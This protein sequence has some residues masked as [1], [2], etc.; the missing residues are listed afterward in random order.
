MPVFVC[1]FAR[2][3]L[4]EAFGI[5][6]VISLA[7]T[8]V[9]IGF[10]AELGVIL[11]MTDP[12][13][14]GLDR[15]TQLYGLAC[16]MAT[17]IIGSLSYIIV[18]KV[19]HLHH[20]VILF[21]F[22]WVAAIETSVITYFMDGFRL[23]ACGI[24][25]WLLTVLSVLSFYA[26]MLLTRALQIEEAGIVSVSRSSAELVLA[27]IFQITLFRQIPDGCT[28]IGSLLVSCAVVLTSLRK[29]IIT[30]PGDH[31]MRRW[32]AFTLK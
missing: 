12:G 25:P 21:N 24:A 10:T 17:T 13:E 18:R 2:I 20:S 29:Y 7:V 14:H 26:Q 31:F 28:I 5:F 15:T 22:A 8:L 9:G 19:K 23:P 1:I 6:H 16:G 4:K 11:G 30:L 3:F 32:F 27:F